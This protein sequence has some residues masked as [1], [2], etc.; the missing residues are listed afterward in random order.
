[1]VAQKDRKKPASSNPQKDNAAS[2]CVGDKQ[3]PR[4]SKGHCS[5][6]EVICTGY[7]FMHQNGDPKCETD[8]RVQAFRDILKCN[9][10][11]M[12]FIT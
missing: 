6:F 10:I 7:D 12:V 3:V 8:H 1:M 9:K 11:E 5:C 2:L 4:G